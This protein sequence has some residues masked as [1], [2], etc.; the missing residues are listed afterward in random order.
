MDNQNPN[1]QYNNQSA[2]SSETAGSKVREVQCE[3]GMFFS[4]EFCP[5]CGKQRKENKTSTCSCGYTGPESNFCP[6][7]G[8]PWSIV[9]SVIPSAPTLS[10]DDKNAKLEHGWRDG[11]GQYQVRFKDGQFSSRYVVTAPS[12]P[13]GI[14]MPTGVEYRIYSNYEFA[15]W[16]EEGHS[17]PDLS[18]LRSHPGE[19]F[20]VFPRSYCYNDDTGRNIFVIEKIWYGMNTLHMDL[21]K[22]GESLRFTVDLELD[23][24]VSIP[25]PEPGAGWT[26][27]RC[28]AKLQPEGKCTKCGAEI[29]TELLFAISEYAPT[30]PPRC[31]GIK[32]WKFS[33]TQLIM[34]R[35]ENYR[36]IPATVIETAMEIIRDYEIDKWEEFKDRMS[37]QMGGSMSVSY[38]DGEKMVGTSTD[39]MDGAAG[40]YRALYALFITAKND[41]AC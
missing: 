21:L 8:R 19:E 14:E 33:D 39:H 32:V 13:A 30:I 38:W 27:S 17:W 22:W 15:P 3:C 11:N 35:G 18:K 24:G 12:G 6:E 9:S 20:D 23:E 37:G 40:A 28:G 1:Y 16:T 29:K 2:V 31:D 26:C 36:F 34:Q 7:C 10:D 5:N 41:T 25:D 4:S